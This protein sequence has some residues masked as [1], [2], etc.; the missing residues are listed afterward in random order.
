MPE[1]PIATN[2]QDDDLAKEIGILPEVGKNI[3]DDLYISVVFVALVT[4]VGINLS[5][6][7]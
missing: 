6:R 7:K 2:I 3:A 5:K 1:E 4:T